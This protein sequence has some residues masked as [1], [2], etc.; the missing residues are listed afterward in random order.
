MDEKRHDGNQTSQRYVF[1]ERHEDRV[2]D[3]P[4]VG[5]GAN[6]EKELFRGRGREG[7]GGGGGG[8][9]GGR[10]RATFDIGSFY[11]LS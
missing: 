8:G 9:G 10:G 4:A 5:L 7:K 11:S 6:V 2:V 3:S 1:H